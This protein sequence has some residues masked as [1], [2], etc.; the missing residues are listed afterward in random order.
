MSK[1]FAPDSLG[2]PNEGLH[3]NVGGIAIFDVALTLGA[4]YLIARRMKWDF[5]LTTVG[6]LAVGQVAH[7]YY[8]VPTA[9]TK[10]LGLY[11]PDPRARRKQA[12]AARL[13]RRT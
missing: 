5:A 3:T 6:L 1:L 7:W 12:Q 13:E 9:V 4:S 10:E 8:R 11:E 2:K